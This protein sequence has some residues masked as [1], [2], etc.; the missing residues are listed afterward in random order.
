MIHFD[1]TKSA[2]SGH[3]SGLLRV[4]ARLREALG[5][6]AIGVIWDGELRAFPGGGRV[7]P[8]PG[9]W[10]VST[11]IATDAERPGLAEFLRA[12]QVRTVAIFH[13]AI[14][15]KF[16]AITWPQSVAR[17]PAY[18]KQLAA[19]DRVWAVSAASR[20]E[21]VEFW[22][23]QGVERTPPVDVLALGADFDGRPRAVGRA[24]PVGAIPQVLCVGILEPR[25][26]QMLL[27][28]VAEALWAEGLV[29]QL[30]L[31]GRM[32]P[33]FGRPI[34]ARIE[35]MRRKYFGLR[36]HEAAEDGTVAELYRLARASVFPTLAEGCGL[37]LL[38]SLW[39]GVPCVC[40][41]LPVLR[42]NAAGGGCLP[43]SVNDVAAWTSALRRV[44]TEDDLVAR[45]EREAGVRALPTWAAAAETLRSALR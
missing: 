36:Y 11:E 28:D 26:N 5:T 15:V 32:N 22:R 16:P 6:A 35:A 31:V 44:L 18:M 20:A 7:E 27:L 43:V 1:V 17:H 23:W 19:R 37:P 39:R 45:L 34:V 3:R 29:F 2:R 30:H 8:K 40:S 38:E 13:D 24:V 41:D 33:H 4:N 25:K 12:K 14:P 42:E 21:L 10:F 9:D